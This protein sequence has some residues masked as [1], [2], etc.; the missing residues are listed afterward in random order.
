MANHGEPLARRIILL[1]L[2]GFLMPPLVWL[3]S[4]KTANLVETWGEMLALALSPLMHIYIAAYMVAVVFS[5]RRQISRIGL[6][7]G[8]RDEK[9]LAQ[10]RVAARRIPALFVVYMSFYCILGPS[11][12][13]YGKAF[14][15]NTEYLL[16]ELMAI[17]IILI[18]A[19]PFLIALV[20]ATEQMSAALPLSERQAFF[21]VGTKMFF[22]SIVSISGGLLFLLLMA[23]SLLLKLPSLSGINDTLVRLIA[24]FFLIVT[25]TLFNLV[26]MRGQIIR[27]VRDLDTRLA[28]IASAQGDLSQRLSTFSRDEFGSIAVS[29][30]ELMGWIAGLIGQIRDSSR[31]IDLAVETLV[32]TARE[33]GEFARKQQA[34]LEQSIGQIHSVKEMVEGNAATAGEARTGM[35]STREQLSRKARDISELVSVMDRVAEKMRTIGGIARQTNMLALNAT[36]EAARAGEAGRGFA[37]V[38]TEV[39]KLATSSRESAQEIESVVAAA[40]EAVTTTMGAFRELDSEIRTGAGL[41]EQIAASGSE[42]ARRL[43][44]ARED[45]AELAQ[46]TGRIAEAARHIHESAGRIQSGGADLSARVSGLRTS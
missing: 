29:F 20:T 8:T 1:S 37:V 28:Q 41:T 30:N 7:I 18:F 24:C 13:L 39:G 11:T 32:I 33:L 5:M 15:S 44:S 26:R 6:A 12:P 25:I 38:A 35:V 43:F 46:I 16:A 10:G 14:I 4:L 36:I 45:L 19:I 2:A 31:Q 3:A 34:A 40:Q 17:P 21:R 42:S 27:P 22:F 23:I 9:I